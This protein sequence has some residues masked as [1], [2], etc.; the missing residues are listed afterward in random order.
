MWLFVRPLTSE[1]QA[2]VEALTRSAD[3]VTY[4]RARTILLS[5]QGQRVPEIMA[6]LGL[7]DRTVR[8]TIHAFDAAGVAA[9]P[10]RK[11][12]G[13][14]RICDAARREALLELLHR[15][16][17]DFGIESGLWTAPDLAA[18]AQQ[19]GLV[20]TISPDTV[21]REVRRSGQSWQR[22]KRWTNSPDPAYTEKRGACSG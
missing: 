6:S 14:P 22:A 5:A 2:Q 4:R 15:P 1:E 18:V 9:L 11:A 17:T 8:D 16:P 3:T 21:R 7:S 12:P 13:K 10:R 20:P 19:Q